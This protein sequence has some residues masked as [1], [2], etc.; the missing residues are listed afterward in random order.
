METTLRPTHYSRNYF[1]DHDALG[2]KV[3]RAL[4]VIQRC[5]RD[6]AGV[7]RGWHSAWTGVAF[8]LVYSMLHRS[9]PSYRIEA[10][11]SSTEH[12]HQGI[13]R[14]D[15]GRAPWSD[16]SVT[17]LESVGRKR[18]RPIV[19]NGTR[20]RIRDSEYC[21]NPHGSKCSREIHCWER[22]LEETSMRHDNAISASH[23]VMLLLYEIADVF[24]VD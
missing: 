9:T 3:S 17:L 22:P 21:L 11:G 23:L 15:L 24:K 8:S 14:H 16:S 2:M 12:L 13:L 6:D 1:L 7:G 20:E 19:P 18:A 5:C 4:D 10:N